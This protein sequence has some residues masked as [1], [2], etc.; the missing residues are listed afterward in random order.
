[1]QIFQSKQENTLV[2]EVRG[3]LDAL[4]AGNLEEECDTWIKTG[5]KDLLLDLGGVD[6]ISSAGLRAILLIG[7]K[8]HALSGALRFCN[9]R[10]MVRE[11]FSI[12]GFNSMFPVYASL[13]EALQQD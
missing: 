7:R 8:L 6:Y 2:L 10:G 4:T 11:V 1:M 13:P 3:R 9:L 12:S 5:E